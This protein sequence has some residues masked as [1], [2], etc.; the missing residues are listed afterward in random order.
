MASRLLLA[1]DHVI[2]RSGIKNLLLNEGF[3]IV[4]EAS[5][6]QE[7]I[8]LV[9][10]FDP[11]VAVLDI[12][13]PLLN[14]ID[15]AREIRAA[16]PRTKVVVL[17]MHK[18]ERFAL[19]ALRSGVAGYVLK[20][21][22]TADLAQAIRTVLQGD[23]YLSPAISGTVVTAALGKTTPHLVALTPRE[24]QV[25]QLI[26]E[27]KTNKEI[28]QHLDISVKSVESHRGNLMKKLD[29]HG[30]AGLVRYAINIGLVQP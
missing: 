14:G 12:S 6:G 13:M 26:A 10:K 7:A 30:I 23:T 20:T 19:E 28:A 15:A 27:S 25:L 2:V 17:T 18:Q 21:Q 11:D 3:E 24:R 5:N 29:L 1:D 4:A 16:S 8:K 22:A 9:E